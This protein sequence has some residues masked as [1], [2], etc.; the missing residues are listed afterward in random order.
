MSG[1][2]LQGW[3]LNG[4]FGISGVQSYQLCKNIPQIL[5]RSTAASIGVLLHVEYRCIY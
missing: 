3:E 2:L 1:S 5:S 4:A